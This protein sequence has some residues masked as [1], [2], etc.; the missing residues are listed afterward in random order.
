[1]IFKLSVLDKKNK[2]Y[3]FG[4]SVK[5]INEIKQKFQNRN[6]I[7]C[8]HIPYSKVGN[9]IKKVDVCILPYTS[10]ITVSGN[11]GN[12]SKFTSPLKIFDFSIIEPIH[13]NGRTFARLLIINLKCNRD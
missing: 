4:G 11:V 6:V 5:Q 9:E 12:I 2:Y 3:M 1:M 8:P 7:F 10:K 13:R